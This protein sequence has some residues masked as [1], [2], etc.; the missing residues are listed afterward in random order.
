MSGTEDDKT[1]IKQQPGESDKTRVSPSRKSPE[2]Q[3][4]IA[5]NKKAQQHSDKTRIPNQNVASSNASNSDDTTKFKPVSKNPDATRIKPGRASTVPPVVNKAHPDKPEVISKFSVLKDRFILE[6][7]LGTGGMGIVYKAKDMLKVEAKDRDP[8]VAIKVLSDEFK[9]H[10]E[11]FITLQ[12]ESRKSQRIAHPNIVS[13]YDFDR[14]GDTIFMTMEHMEGKPLDLLIRQYQ[15]TGLPTDDVWEL[16]KGIC[17]ALM[18]AHEENII[19]SDLKPGNIFVTNRGSAKIFDFGIARAVSQAET[20]ESHSD[21]RTIFDAG[22]LGALTPAYA[23]LEMLLGEKPDARDDIYALGCVA[24]E[25]F[26]GEHPF[27]KV[28][29]DEAQQQGLKPRRIRELTKKQWRAVEQAL[30]FKRENRIAS[31]QEFFDQLTSKYTPS[32]KIGIILA[33]SLSVFIVVYFLY[34][35]AAPEVL[36]EDDIRNALEFEIRLGLHKETMLKLLEGVTFSERWE[37]SIWDEVQELRKLL[38]P[39]DAWLQ[40]T[41]N[42]I[43][44]NYIVKISAFRNSGKIK[45]ASGLIENAYRYTKDPAALDKEKLLL[46]DALKEQELRM[47]AQ[48]KKHSQ[49]I[50]ENSKKQIIENESRTKF[51]V[52]LDNVNQQLRC[53]SRLNMRNI[54]AAIKKLKSI[55]LSRYAKLKPKL[56]TAMAACI[57]QVGKSFPEKAGESKKYAMRI[58]NGHPE[59]A[60]IKIVARDP[61]D[62]SIAGL[63]ARGKRAICRDVI[64][65]IGAGPALVVVPAS[66]SVGAFAIG[67]Y[68]ISVAELNV[69]CKRSSECNQINNVDKNIPVTGIPVSTI[70]IYLRWLSK[71]TNRKYRLPTKTEWIYASKARK[72]KLDPNRNCRLSSRGIK[73]GNELVSISTGKQNDWGV[74][75]YVGN[76]QELIYDK[77][78]QLAAVGGSYNVSMEQCNTSY[79]ENHSGEPDKLTGFRILRELRL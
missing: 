39:E 46:A 5:H 19:H 25:L 31:V 60:A 48:K 6:D 55:N 74:V 35:K 1:R 78:R 9:S 52:A 77:G 27:N 15:S 63:G 42:T 20:R 68:E 41:E 58:F 54:D 38:K 29:A 57:T 13:V 76:A 4:R 67:K 70:K 43:Y 37:S 66:R 79:L 65:D 17:A 69:F 50:S 32:S 45:R 3:T 21:D 14:D 28:P 7:V 8:Y 10:P 49:K 72:N 22:N 61:C 36:N 30:A 47:K 23:S 18:H 44:A 53:Q 24:Y 64:K 11:A 73:K 62:L 75:N 26:T 34:I 59:I 33:L 16:L 71:K 40:S 56:I 51:N 2:D 12:R